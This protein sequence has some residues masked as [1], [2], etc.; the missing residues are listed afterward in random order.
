M[1]CIS[2]EIHLGLKIKKEKITAL[3]KNPTRLCQTPTVGK[4]SLKHLR[5]P[6]MDGFCPSQKAFYGQINVGN[7]GGGRVEKQIMS[8]TW[9]GIFPV[10]LTETQIKILPIMYLT[11]MF[12][13][14]KIRI[15]W[16]NDLIRLEVFTAQYIHIARYPTHKLQIQ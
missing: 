12:T 11:Q 8:N 13:P 9:F 5:N 15:P 14:N 1:D 2:L 10:N 7:S 4:T 16:V 6:N 3:A